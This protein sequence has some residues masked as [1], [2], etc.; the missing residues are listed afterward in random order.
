MNPRANQ[1]HG[2]CQ[3]MGNLVPFTRLGYE[4][5]QSDRLTSVRAFALAAVRHRRCMHKRM[6]TTRDEWLALVKVQED[7]GKSAPVFCRERGIGYQNFHK[8]RDWHC[9]YSLVLS[10]LAVGCHGRDVSASRHLCINVEVLCYDTYATSR[11]EMTR[12][13]KK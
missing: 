5:K 4:R 3:P 11:L 1:W 7:S 9:R 8:C 10:G 2:A 6:R 12:I 13:A